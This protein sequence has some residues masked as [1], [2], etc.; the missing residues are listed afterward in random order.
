[1]I[2]F[3]RSASASVLV[4]VAALGCGV[5]GFVYAHEPARDEIVVTVDRTRPAD[6][7]T[8]LSGTVS[9]AGDGRLVVEG[10]GGTTDLALPATTPIE[11]LQPVAP[12]ALAAGVLV[13][14]GAE[15]SDYGV[16]LTGVVMVGGR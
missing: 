3:Q 13:N 12:S 15:R 8:I 11:E 6:A 2:L 14:I 5:A 9:R 10:E 4:L 1:M 16:A 7:P